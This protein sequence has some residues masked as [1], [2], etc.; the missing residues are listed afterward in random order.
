MEIWPILFESN[1]RP[2]DIEECFRPGGMFEPYMWATKWAQDIGPTPPGKSTAGSNVKK[3][4][5]KNVVFDTFG[6]FMPHS[7]QTGAQP[8][9]DVVFYQ[10]KFFLEPLRMS[11][12]GPSISLGQKKCP[13]WPPNLIIGSIIFPTYL[14]L[15]WAIIWACTVGWEIT[16]KAL[17]LLHKGEETPVRLVYVRWVTRLAFC[18]RPPQKHIVGTHCGSCTVGQVSPLPEKNGQRGHPT[19]FLGQFF[20]LHG[21]KLLWL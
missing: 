1:F 10:T 12:S 3:I 13:K 19:S 21:Q 18:C 2:L 14:K 6:Q 20:F 8:H 16:P 11:H 4:W 7:G 15:V 17:F 5:P 9:P